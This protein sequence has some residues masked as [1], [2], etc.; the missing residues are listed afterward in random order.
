MIHRVFIGRPTFGETQSNLDFSKLML[1]LKF[2]GFSG[3]NGFYVSF[4]Q[5]KKGLCQDLAD[6]KLKHSETILD[7]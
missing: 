2:Y 3:S 4:F 1:K 6:V 5:L 7:L